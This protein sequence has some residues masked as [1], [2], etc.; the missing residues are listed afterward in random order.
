MTKTNYLNDSHTLDFDASVTDVIADENGHWI[1]L[2]RTFFYPEGGG[3]PCDLGQINDFTV[4]DVQHRLDSVY[5]L[6]ASP[7]TLGAT[8]NCHVDADRRLDMMQQHTGQHLLSHGLEH[9]FD[10]ATIGFHLTEDNLTVD[11]DKKLGF[12]DLDKLEAYCNALIRRNLKVITHYP[13]PETLKTMPL[14]KQPKVTEGIRI[15]EID[16]LD[17]S[18]CGGTHLQAIGPIQ[19]I[20]IKRFE[21]YK[22]GTRIE[23][24]CGMRALDDYTK[25]SLWIQTL[26]NLLSASQD[27]LISSVERLKDENDALKKTLMTFKE[28]QLKNDIVEAIAKRSKRPYGDFAIFE[29]TD[30]DPQL[31]RKASAMLTSVVNGVSLLINTSSE[32]YQLILAQSEDKL[33]ELQPL[34]ADLKAQ[35]GLKGG[36]NAVALQGGG[37]ISQLTEIKCYLLEKL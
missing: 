19:L 18:P 30:L 29:S 20:K 31:F 15:I 1:E 5:H 3:Q 24:V 17:F 28:Q 6:I 16:G 32:T 33:Y 22:A 21:N 35:Y 8:V 13:D 37:D 11:A 2:D 4:L 23:F 9:L 25:K 7:L 36:G 27:T 14:R 12:E 34:F 10:A 26:T